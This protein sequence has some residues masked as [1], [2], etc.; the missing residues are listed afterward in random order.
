[1]CEIAW[2]I[3]F[4][5]RKLDRI[6]LK[7]LSNGVPSLNEKRLKKQLAAAESLLNVI[8]EHLKYVEAIEKW[9]WELVHTYDQRAGISN[10]YDLYLQKLYP[11]T[12]L[13]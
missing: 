8:K 3:L 12:L 5:K 11:S 10:V 1:M 13:I 7:S 9:E 4:L 6:K 2:K